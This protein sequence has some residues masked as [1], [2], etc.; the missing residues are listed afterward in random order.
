MLYILIC[1]SAKI[2]HFSY[3]GNKL[4]HWKSLPEMVKFFDSLEELTIFDYSEDLEK[5][6]LQLHQRVTN[7]TVIK[8]EGLSVHSI[9]S[10][11]RRNGPQIKV[12]KIDFSLNNECEAIIDSIYNRM[13][14][15]QIF[16]AFNI[17]DS[18]IKEFIHDIEMNELIIEFKNF[19]ELRLISESIRIS[20]KFLKTSGFIKPSNLES[21]DEL[22]P[23]CEELSLNNCF[24]FCECSPNSQE[25]KN[26]SYYSCEEC[27]EQCLNFI[28]QLPKIQYL[29]INGSRFNL[30]ED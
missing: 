6:F 27:L 13:T 8:C 3:G 28:T 15:L 12:L 24:I 9:V 23:E 29:E 20:L 22:I 2:I 18:A 21:I 10:L 19:V 7:L 17:N 1:F 11:T 5:V 16:K 14:E 25:M 26:N 4:N 30:Y